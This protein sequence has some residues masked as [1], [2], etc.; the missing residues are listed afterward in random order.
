MFSTGYKYQLSELHNAPPLIYLKHNDIDEQAA[1]LTGYDQ[2]YQQ[3]SC[4]H[5]NGSFL[6]CEVDNDLAMYFEYTN[7]ALNQTA[8]VPDGYF[9][10]GLL[11]ESPEPTVFNSHVFHKSSAFIV[12]PNTVIEGTTAAGMN[13]CIVHVSI[14]LI[15]K[16]CSDQFSRI[17]NDKSVDLSG[18]FVKSDENTNALYA[19]IC[20]FMR[21]AE[22]GNL[23]LKQKNQLATFK[24]A[25][26]TAIEWAFVQ[27][28]NN[29]VNRSGINT[30]RSH[31]IFHEAG[32][33]IKNKLCDEIS[34]Q[35]ICDQLQ[36]SRRI[37]EYAFHK[38]IRMS[39]GRYIKLLRLNNIRR[40]ILSPEN[41]SIPIGDL[42]AKWGV[43][44]L[45]R[46]AIDYCNLFDE[47]PSYTRKSVNF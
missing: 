24:Y 42:A 13:I 21:G 2:Q 22:E 12:S 11:L 15:S 47:L 7:Q 31:I 16:F 40:E 30:N 34:V 25:L 41:Y 8:V 10:I 4:G 18:T 37:L 5:F 19:L 36:V 27:A 43:W 44:H 3:L 26:V 9:A 39:P 28:G 14:E 20:D 32:D 35:Y 45:S 38:N 29:S 6:T 23:Y 1:R 17:Y 33:L 46:F